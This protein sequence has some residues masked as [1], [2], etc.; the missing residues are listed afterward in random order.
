MGLML[1]G[2]LNLRAQQIIALGRNSDFRMVKVTGHVQ[3]EESETKRMVPLPNASVRIYNLT[4]SVC[5]TSRVTDKDGNFTLMAY[6]SRKSDYEVQISYLGTDTYTCK[7]RRVNIMR[8]DTV[9]LHEKPITMEEAVI[10]A[11]LKKMRILGDTT[12]FNADAFRV[13]EGAVLLEL[14]RRLPGLRI[15]EGKM[16][17]QGKD[18]NEILVNG[19]KF[20]ADDISV[21]LQ[22][23]PVN[24]LKEVRIYDKKSEKAEQTGVDDGQRTT[25][26]DLK[27][28]QELSDALM[29]NVSAGAGDQ[30]LYGLNGMFNYFESG[31]DNASA[32]A[33]QHNTPNDIGMDPLAGGMWSGS[34]FS[35]GGSPMS[36]LS[37]RTGGSVGH[38]FGKVDVSASVIYD[39]SSR[40]TRTATESES[41]LPSGNTYSYSTAGSGS[42]GD[43]LNVNLN[44]NGE[45]T[46]R[47]FVTGSFSYA[48][49]HNQSISESLNA[50]FNT[51][52]GVDDPLAQDDAIPQS[53]KVNRTD[54]RSMS[55]GND[56]AFNGMLML[57]HRFRKDKRNLTLQL[58][59]YGGGNTSRSFQR[60]ATRYY[61]L[62]DSIL[63]QDRFSLN[64]SH[65]PNLT[66]EL[67]YHEPLTAHLGLE[68]SYGFDI[69][70][71]K[72]DNDIFDLGRFP[73]ADGER[74]LGSLPEGYESARIDSLSSRDNEL[75][76]THH[77][78]ISLD[79]NLDKWLLNASFSLNRREQVINMAQRGRD[80]DTTLNRMT[81]DA[82]M[83]AHYFSDKL[84]ISLTY[85]G[86]SRIP[87]ITQLVPIVDNDN[88]LYVTMGNP[89]LKSSY[90]H[91]VNANVHYGRFWLNASMQQTFNSID[92][93][94]TYDP[95]SGVRTSRPDNI[96]G[97]WNVMTDLG[98][99]HDWEQFG[100]E[101][102]T[103]YTYSRMPG[104]VEVDTHITRETVRR[105]II[106]QML[107][108]SYTPEWGEFILT[109]SAN[110]DCTRAKVQRQSDNN[111]R[112]YSLMAEAGVYLP[113]NIRLG[114]NFN[115]ITRRGYL[116]DESNGTEFLWNANASWSFL[117]KKQASLKLEVYDILRRATNLQSTTHA[118]GTTQ[119][120]SH[121]INSYV[122]LS[123][124]YRFNMFGG[125]KDAEN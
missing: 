6:P 68:L 115:S 31:G 8:L 92:Y 63:R 43:N 122:L 34:M 45:L 101:G 67:S 65:M 7:L 100:I 32:F 40:D 48:R 56:D 71:E 77:V 108:G 78:G 105:N 25:V 103:G 36:Q 109:A 88:P 51:P 119:T 120:R 5:Q 99:S 83:M 102:E 3:L 30:G 76:R 97:Q 73:V 64:S 60:S 52:P 23:M 80:I 12:I 81:Y 106:R 59:G 1:A 38:K 26:M 118:T 113:W 75:E 22:N 35:F 19:E 72:S 33:N 79:L 84:S 57:T 46:E 96:N 50:T 44:I 62:G 70:R 9:T 49:M 2:C 61:Q 15:S 91:H 93:V 82:H 74:P 124:H 4:D 24:L 114:T 85:N 17:Y 94:T 98:Y 11:K 13:S 104:Y 123:F 54:N 58:T 18:I 116:S 47:L 117:K 14:V 95:V 110:F 87:T 10:V 16:T 111:T 37:R 39:D 107:R 42:G 41:Y 53:A 27:T 89:D 125:K 69:S 86:S 112:T 20:F 121:G 28:K 29:A 55:R 21:A 66:T 90:T